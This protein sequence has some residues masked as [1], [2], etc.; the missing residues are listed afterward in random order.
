MEEEILE[1]DKS[2]DDA[3]LLYKMKQYKFTTKKEISCDKAIEINEDDIIYYKKIDNILIFDK[4]LNMVDKPENDKDNNDESISDKDIEYMIDLIGLSLNGENLEK[5]N[6]KELDEIV[7]YD[8]RNQ[9]IYENMSK[10]GET[11][12]PDE[13]LDEIFDSNI[14][15][16]SSILYIFGIKRDG[17]TYYSYD[18]TINLLNDISNE[19]GDVNFKAQYW[20]NKHEYIN[21]EHGTINLNLM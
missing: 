8:T 3:V 21:N 19:I 6:K 11:I 4:L 15:T 14:L 2:I 7:L 20:H 10:F 17:I 18:T 16:N 1:F 13:K 5:I 12:K 9:Y